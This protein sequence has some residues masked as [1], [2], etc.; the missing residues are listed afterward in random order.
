MRRITRG[1]AIFLSYDSG[2]YGKGHLTGALDAEHAMAWS[3]DAQGRVTGKGQ[4]VGS[5]TKS[6][7]YGYS[8]GWTYDLLDYLI[9]QIPWLSHA[10]LALNLLTGKSMNPG[11]EGQDQRGKAVASTAGSS[12]ADAV[13][14]YHEADISRS[15][16]RQ[17]ELLDR[18]GS[19]MG[20]RHRAAINREVRN[21]ASARASAKIFRKVAGPFAAAAGLAYDVSQCD[22]CKQ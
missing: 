5:I 21:S 10:E 11:N 1:R 7:G 18:P 8:L 12:A 19:K 3:Y 15:D 20:Q 13:A 16:A 6:I 4:T 17:R 22:P 14:R 9:N 2:T